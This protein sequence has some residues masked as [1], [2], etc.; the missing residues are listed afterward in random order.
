ML[1]TLSLI[2]AFAISAVVAP[3]AQTVSPRDKAK[4]AQS[5]AIVNINTASSA[6]LEALPGIGPKVAARIIDYR[7]TKGPFKKIEE[8]MNV[9]GIGEKSFLKLRSQVTVGPKADAAGQD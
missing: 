8:L 2:L 6:E 5:V 1:R 7:K 4:P 9:Q 3:L